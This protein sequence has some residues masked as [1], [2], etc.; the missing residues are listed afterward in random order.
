M[1][2]CCCQ[3]RL[4]KTQH[5]RIEGHTHTDAQRRI[6]KDQP[7]AINKGECLLQF[8]ELGG[9]QAQHWHSAVQTER[10]ATGSSRLA[11]CRA[12]GLTSP[13]P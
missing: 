3:G 4:D 1:F 2:V 13:A 12:A 5:T 10:N 11:A 9:S 8:V 6:Q 7:N